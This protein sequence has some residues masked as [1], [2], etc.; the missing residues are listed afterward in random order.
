MDPAGDDWQ[1][2]QEYAAAGSQAAFRA[3]VDRHVGMVYSTARRR[4]GDA[5]RAEDVTQAV[6]IILSQKARIMRRGTPLAPWLFNV[7]RHTTAN[8][9][10]IDRRRKVHEQR[11]ALQRPETVSNPP[12]DEDERM[13][14][15]LDGAMD[16]LRESDR[17]VILLRFFQ[18]QAFAQIAAALSISAHAA[19]VRAARAVEKL[20]RYFAAQGLLAAS[21]TVAATLSA[22]VADAAP[23]GVHT[24]AAAAALGKAAGAPAALAGAAPKLG[25]GLLVKGVVAASVVVAAVVGEVKLVQW[26]AQSQAQHADAAMQMA[27]GAPNS[28]RRPSRSPPILMRRRLCASSWRTKAG[29]ITSKVST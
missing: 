14:A 1:L 10:K 28:P 11:A 6:F 21:G 12:A 9:M 26:M 18:V 29:L 16:S 5:H 4:L 7:A 8:A 13:L 19:E 27:A 17:A 23:S 20:R 15:L 22:R 2:L 24:I 3:L 25:A